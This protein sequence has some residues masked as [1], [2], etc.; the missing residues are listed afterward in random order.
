MLDI[1]SKAGLN[2][3]SEYLVIENLVFIPLNLIT[4]PAT[5]SDTEISK[6]EYIAT[7]YIAVYKQDI[8]QQ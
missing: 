7:I 1:L 2:K 5:S 3:D 8:L 6:G 4:T